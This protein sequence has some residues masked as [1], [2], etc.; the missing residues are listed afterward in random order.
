MLFVQ[1]I[2]P[3]PGIPDKAYEV[4]LVI[5]KKLQWFKTLVCLEFLHVETSIK[6]T[7][8]DFGSRRKPEEFVLHNA[9][10]IPS[11]PSCLSVSFA[12]FSGR[13]TS[14]NYDYFAVIDLQIDLLWSIA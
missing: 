1:G 3:Y 10:L 4:T 7:R 14:V 11:I 9:H 8:Y 6:Y 13:E 2:F 12:P 5:R